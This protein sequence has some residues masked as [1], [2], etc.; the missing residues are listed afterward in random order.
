MPHLLDECTV[1]LLKKFEGQ[2]LIFMNER[3]GWILLTMRSKS[4]EDL[5][6][7]LE[8]VITFMKDVLGHMIER[9]SDTEHVCCQLAERGAFLDLCTCSRP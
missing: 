7:A 5:K 8:Q 2:K 3:L 4:A 1:P 9:V 6:G